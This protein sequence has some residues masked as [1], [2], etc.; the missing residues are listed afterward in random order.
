MTRGRSVH[1][2][3]YGVYMLEPQK[4]NTYKGRLSQ[5]RRYLRPVGVSS[6]RPDRSGQLKATTRNPR[7]PGT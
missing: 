5:V 3:N 4:S 6:R 7:R 1:P 2:C